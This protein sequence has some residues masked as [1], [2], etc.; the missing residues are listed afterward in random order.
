VAIDGDTIEV[1]VPYDDTA[2]GN[3]AGSADVFGPPHLKF[4]IGSPDLLSGY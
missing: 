1:R 2:A 3:I 4:F